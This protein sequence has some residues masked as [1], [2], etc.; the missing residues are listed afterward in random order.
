[1]FVDDSDSFLY[2]ENARKWYCC[3]V[4]P[5]S[6][7]MEQ[8]TKNAD[9]DSPVLILSAFPEGQ[10]IFR[11]EHDGSFSG[12]FHRTPALYGFLDRDKYTQDNVAY[13]QPRVVLEVVILP[14]HE[15]LVASAQRIVNVVKQKLIEA[16]LLDDGG[17]ITF[18]DQCIKDEVDKV[19]ATSSEDGYN[20]HLKLLVQEY[21]ELWD[22]EDFGI[23]GLKMGSSMDSRDTWAVDWTVV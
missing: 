16:R 2:N 4:P 19:A 5:N 17:K 9:F 7:V 18:R 6:E 3:T 22:G 12:G 13:V 8:Y 23:D 15:K 21:Y 14:D 1:M 20:A 11:H 10:T